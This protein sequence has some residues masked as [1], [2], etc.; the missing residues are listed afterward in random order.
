MLDTRLKG[1]TA[2]LGTSDCGSVVPLALCTI[3]RLLHN[4]FV[5]N[6]SH[7]ITVQTVLVLTN[8]CLFWT[9][10]LSPGCLSRHKGLNIYI[11][12]CNFNIWHLTVGEACLVFANCRYLVTWAP[13]VLVALCWNV[14]FWFKKCRRMEL[15]LIY[16][17]CEM[18]IHQPIT[19]LCCGFVLI[20]QAFL[21]ITTTVMCL[22]SLKAQNY[23]GSLYLCTWI[24]LSQLQFTTAF[25]HC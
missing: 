1:Y 5:Y 11:F 18:V 23:E 2:V 21:F 3:P 15:Y 8:A 25:L 14:I 22:L 13:G 16:M 24:I 6:Q 4:C 12:I 10:R 19:F 9:F 20:D 17:L 7:V